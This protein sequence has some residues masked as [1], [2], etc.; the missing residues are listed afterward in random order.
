M[1]VD[2]VY[3]G[4]SVTKSDRGGSYRQSFDLIKYDSIRD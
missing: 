2:Q 3:F 4:E 1:Q